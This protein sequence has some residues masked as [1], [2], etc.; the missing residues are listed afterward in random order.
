MLLDIGGYWKLLDK[1]I[2]GYWIRLQE[3]QSQSA[4]LTLKHTETWEAGSPS[5]CHTSWQDM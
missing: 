3:L 4:G 2:R 1:A 5:Q